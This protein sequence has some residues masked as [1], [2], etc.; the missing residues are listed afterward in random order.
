[1]TGCTINNV[2]GKQQTYQHQTRLAAWPRRPPQLTIQTKSKRCLT[3]SARRTSS[4]T[5]LSVSQFG[6]V[7]RGTKSIL[8]ICIRPTN[9]CRKPTKENRGS[10]MSKGTLSINMEILSSLNFNLDSKRSRWSSKKWNKNSQI[11]SRNPTLKTS[12]SNEDYSAIS[13]NLGNNL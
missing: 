4:T 3:W 2:R 5:S 13:L 8:R 7:F 1:M 11:S 9:L 12:L 10:L 6:W